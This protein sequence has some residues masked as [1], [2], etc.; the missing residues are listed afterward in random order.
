M[1]EEKGRETGRKGSLPGLTA[2]KGTFPGGKINPGIPTMYG[3][4]KSCCSRPGRKQ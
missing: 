2:T 1:M 4:L 3:F